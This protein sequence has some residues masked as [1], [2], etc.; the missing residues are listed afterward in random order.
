VNFLKIFFVKNKVNSQC[1]DVIFYFAEYCKTCNR[2]QV[3][4]AS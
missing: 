2:S 4:N 3:S 1:D